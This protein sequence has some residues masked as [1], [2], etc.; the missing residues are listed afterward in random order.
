MGIFRKLHEVSALNFE[1]SGSNCALNQTWVDTLKLLYLLRSDVREGMAKGDHSALVGAGHSLTK[2]KINLE[3]P[4]EIFK[5]SRVGK[6]VKIYLYLH[7]L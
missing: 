2:T 7:T 1:P 4:F 5:S 3:S 6:T